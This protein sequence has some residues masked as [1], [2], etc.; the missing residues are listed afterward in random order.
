MTTIVL[1][2]G[3]RAHDLVGALVPGSVSLPATPGRRDLRL[4]DDV[5][6]A[7]LPQDDSPSLDEIAAQ[8][9]VPHQAEPQFAP[10]RPDQPVRVVVV[11]S[12]A[13]LAAVVTRLMRIDALW[14][15]VGFVPVGTEMSVVAQNWQLETPEEPDLAALNF[16]MTAPVRPTS[17]VR[18]DAGIVTLGSAE[19][20]HPG[21]ELV[22]EVIVDS[23]TLFMNESS[24]AW[25]GKAGAFGVRMVPTVEAPGL[26]ATR[27]LTP[28]VYDEESAEK[29]LRRR[30]FRRNLEP[31][32]VDHTAVLS[33]RALQAGGV[34]LTVVR[35]GVV[36]PRTVKSVTFYRHLRDGQ[37]VRR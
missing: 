13:A 3:D 35:D 18:D 32:V 31:G 33:G 16:A 11:G 34:G 8:P 4:L 19:I 24:T 25:E 12:D 9:D 14:I 7:H 28:S 20:F 29:A 37:F 5:A 27:L 21:A 15:S 2:C 23:D 22:G 26:A 1:A 30:L 36:H 6:A 10:Q 17:I